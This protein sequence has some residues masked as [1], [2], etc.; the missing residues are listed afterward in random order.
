MAGG[1]N[2]LSYVNTHPAPCTCDEPNFF[3]IHKLYL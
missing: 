2:G 1:N 3:I